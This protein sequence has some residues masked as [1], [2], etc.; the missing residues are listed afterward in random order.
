MSFP[1][2]LSPSPVSEAFKG[3]QNDRLDKFS[4]SE[5]ERSLFQAGEENVM[6]YTLYDQDGAVAYVQ[7]LLKLLDHL[8]SSTTPVSK[9]PLDRILADDEASEFWSEDSRGVMFHYAISKLCEVI[10]SLR[11]TKTKVTLATVFFPD[12]MLL[13]T[14]RPL[15]RVLV[16]GGS[17]EF[18]QRGSAYCLACILLEGCKLQRQAKLFS[19]ID[20]VLD[21]FVSWISS[22]LQSSASR[23]LAVVTPAMTTLV[24]SREARVLFDRAGGI[25]Y[26]SRYLNSESTSAQQVYE[27]CFCMWLLSFDANESMIRHFH[28][29]GAVPVL[30]D[31]VATAPREKVLRCSLS[32]LRNLAA[33]DS[34]FIREM[35]G[36]DLSRSIDQLSERSW[37]D[38]EIESDLVEL[39]KVLSEVHR[40]MTRWDVYQT[41][42][43]STH[44]KWSA[45]H[46]EKFFKENVMKMEGKSGD[47][48]LVR[49]LIHIAATAKPDVASVAC[50]DIGE[51]VRFY[52]NGRA[53]SKRL[54]A[55]EVILHLIENDDEELKRYALMCMSKML[56]KN[57]EHVRS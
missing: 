31:L 29:D 52:P 28:R 3:I 54:G 15:Y 9:L 51:F 47:F 44:L 19:S 11:D 55:R 57:W 27:L 46:N 40:A 49:T 34:Q 45:V 14:W 13:D 18:A 48:A 20:S 1:V 30:V 33:A 24:V 5:H 56:V 41:E 25:A 4:L 2:A 8:A 38:P 32:T 26:M 17:D 35:V 22:R 50:F 10:Q 16:G 12:G 7:L 42:V 39:N 37:K 53:I 43:E 6:E 21:S 36:C 23:T